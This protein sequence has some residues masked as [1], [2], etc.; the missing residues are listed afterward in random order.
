MSTCL[1]GERPSF[2]SPVRPLLS[3]WRVGKALGAV[4]PASCPCL[5]AT[6][7]SPNERKDASGRLFLN[8]QGRGPGRG[9]LDQGS[10]PI[11]PAFP[12][13][14]QRGHHAVLRGEG[15]TACRSAHRTEKLSQHAPRGESGGEPSKREEWTRKPAEECSYLGTPLTLSLSK[16]E[17]RLAR[18]DRS[19][20]RSGCSYFDRL[21]TSG[22]AAVRDHDDVRSGQEG[23]GGMVGREAGHRQRGG[24][25]AS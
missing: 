24:A 4:A 5:V 22:S 6:P 3:C 10:W 11:R 23:D 20:G 25:F 12:W 18:K 16:G 9:R 19:P 14:P 2:P 13:S 17:E 21:S 1:G 8:S 15:A 7:R